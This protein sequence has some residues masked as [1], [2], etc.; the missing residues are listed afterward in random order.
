MKN[1]VLE[2]GRAY[3]SCLLVERSEQIIY[4]QLIVLLVL[5]ALLVHLLWPRVVEVLMVVRVLVMAL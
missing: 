2:L 4:S 3:T 1:S 5:L